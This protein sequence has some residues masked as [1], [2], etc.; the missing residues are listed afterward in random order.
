[1]FSLVYNAVTY[2]LGAMFKPVPLDEVYK[3][4]EHIAELM[5]EDHE[6]GRG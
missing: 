3:E 1:M 2:G 4:T 5:P 6:H